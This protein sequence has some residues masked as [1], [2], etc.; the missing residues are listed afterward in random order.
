M[1]K[2]VI[3][4]LICINIASAICQQVFFP[5]KKG[6][7]LEYATLNEKKKIQSYSK[8][9][10]KE[11]IGTTGNQTIT[12]E[13][14]ALDAKKVP[15][16]EAVTFSVKIQGDKITFDPKAMF[17]GMIQANMEISGTG[18]TVPSRISVGQSW[19]DAESVMTLNMGSSKM[20]TKVKLT[21]R[22]VLLKESI[23]VLAGTYEC[24]KVQQTAVITPPF[25]NAMKEKHY[26][27]YAEGIGH[28]KTERYNDKNQLQSIEELS[29]VK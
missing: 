10:V 1:K 18:N 21:E 25:G 20:E 4:S 23:T 5:V 15:S 13:L 16:S 28:V 17:A 26:M 12:I 29:S 11:V 14:Q 24:Y 22:K 27:W 9:S 7:V 6:T 8:M 2:L 19:S 3:F